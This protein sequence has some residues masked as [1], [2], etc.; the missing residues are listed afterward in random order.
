MASKMNRAVRASP[1]ICHHSLR[2]GSSTIRQTASVTPASVSGAVMVS[3]WR[4]L[5]VAMAA[6][7]VP[8]HGGRLQFGVGIAD[9]GQ[10]ARP[11]PGVDVVEQLV[12]A[13]RRHQLPDL[14]LLV[15]QVAEDDG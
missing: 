8:W 14:A 6:L 2:G 5:S 1:N 9:A 12:A 15:V 10:V 11:R 4:P 7:L 13:L 3:A